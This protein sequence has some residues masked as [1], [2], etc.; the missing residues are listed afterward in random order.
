MQF[1]LN[2]HTSSGW[3]RSILLTFVVSLIA[4]CFVMVPQAKAAYTPQLPKT[5][6]ATSITIVDLYNDWWD[7]PDQSAK[8]GEALEAI[9]ASYV[10]QGI[11]NRTSSNKIYFTHNPDNEIFSWLNVHQDTPAN[12]GPVDIN[13]LN[14]G[15]LPVPQTNAV[16]NTSIKYP[17]LKYLLTNYGSYIKGKVN[18]QTLSTLTSDGNYGSSV[19]SAVITACAQEDAVPVTAGLNSWL[20]TEGISL[21]QKQ[22]TTG[23]ATI[24][25]IYDWAYNTYFANTTRKLIGVGKE[26]WSVPGLIDYFVSSKAFVVALRSDIPNEQTRLQTLLGQYPAGTMLFGRPQDEGQFLSYIESK[27]HYF[28]VEGVPNLSVHSSFPSDS[29][30][31]RPAKAPTAAA[32]IDPNGLYVSFQTTDGDAVNF[33]AK[34]LYNTMHRE[35]AYVGQVPVGLTINPHYLDFFPQLLKWYSNQHHNDAVE[36]VA[37]YHDGNF[38]GTAAGQAAYTSRALDYK[39]NTNN[40]FNGAAIFNIPQA[41]ALPFYWQEIGYQGGTDGNDVSWNLTNNGQTARTNLTG[42][43][44]GGATSQEMYNA[45]KYVSD[46]TQVGQPAFMIVAGGAGFSIDIFQRIAGAKNLLNASPP[47]GRTVYFMRPSDVAATWRAWSFGT[48]ALSRTGWTATASRSGFGDNPGNALD[49]NTS[50]R[51]TTGAPMVNGD[52]YRVDMGAVQSFNKI[53]LDGQGSNDYPRGYQVFVSNDGSSWGSAIAS[54]VGNN[55]TSI[56]FAN[57]NARY[58]KIVQTGSA[59]VNWSIYEFNVYPPSIPTG[60]LS[61]SG[62]TAG[63]SRSGFGDNPGNAIDAVSSNRWTT[64]APMV[65]G[66]Y[67]QVDMGAAKP[68]NKIVLD[69]QGSSGDYPRGYQV[70][71]SNDGS[72]WGSAIASGVGNNLTTI[73]FAS[74]NARY[75]KVV[76]TGSAGVNWSVN[77]FRVYN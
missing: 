15:L 39:N 49:N 30:I 51:W 52:F 75:I 20:Q 55:I 46:R 17:A 71:V 9:I 31:I 53:V 35:S 23:Y 56:T 7:E 60:E 67:Y 74:Q 54:G 40:L 50:S 62:W 13:Y 1:I 29:L 44:Q 73:T 33:S 63:A 69:G 42:T 66:D 68:F 22:D 43:T 58:I 65:N 6:A 38:P 34:W 2:R 4:T 12:G 77:E 16:L 8:S 14:D 59:G 48:P 72:S 61:R 11:V 18:Y 5:P 3:N 26:L 45:A 27:G 24:T 32:S 57:Q 64:G 21:V 10:I 41:D 76:Q 37:H 70:F 28:V 19:F 36:V 47:G 25:A